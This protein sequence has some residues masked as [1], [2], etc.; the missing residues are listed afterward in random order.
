M[1]DILVTDLEAGVRQITLNRPDALNAIN[2]PMYERLQETFDGLKKDFRVRTVVLTGAGRAFAAGHDMRDP[3]RSEAEKDAYGKV[4]LNV[5]TLD[6]V[7]ALIASIKALPQPV[8]AAIKGPVAGIGF[9]LALAADMIVAGETTR[10]V[11]A[12]HN[13]GSDC[14]G[15]L[16]WLLPRAVG[17][18]LAAE[19]LLT[20]R[21]VLADEALRSG[22][23][24]KVVPDDDIVTHALAIARQIAL[25]AP[26]GVYMTK[27]AL[28][29]NMQGASLDQAI[30]FENRGVHTSQASE[31]GAEKLRAFQDKRPPEFRNR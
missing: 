26:L 23:V 11:N 6:K 27:Q 18:Q 12:F 1:D 2:H 22:L 24:L 8:I 16:S 29:M 30:A 25:N 17:T 31:D 21:P 4:Y 19:I 5:L 14:E 10:F 9:S 28:W 13:A 15:G 3:Q 20:G 7:G